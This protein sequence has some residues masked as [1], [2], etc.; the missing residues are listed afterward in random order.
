M[1]KRGAVC[2]WF[3]DDASSTRLNFR[4]KFNDVVSHDLE[5]KYADGIIEG[6]L[7]EDCTAHHIARFTAIYAP[8]VLAR[9]AVSTRR[10]YLAEWR[11]TFTVPCPR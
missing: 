4:S 10:L 6:G 11:M 1:F 3:S 2:K 9:Y 5:K 8:S 7:N